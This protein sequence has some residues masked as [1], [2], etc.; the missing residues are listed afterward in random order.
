VFGCC[1]GGKI[2]DIQAVDNYIS[3]QTR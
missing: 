3:F 1:F 2:T